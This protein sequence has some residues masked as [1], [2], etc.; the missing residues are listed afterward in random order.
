M[1]PPAE[2]KIFWGQSDFHL[3]SQVANEGMVQK[4]GLVSAVTEKT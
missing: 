1:L 3:M 4:I 2:S